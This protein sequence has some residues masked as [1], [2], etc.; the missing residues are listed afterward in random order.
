M[1]LACY[2]VFPA[3][4]DRGGWG[5]RHTMR[6][7]IILVMWREELM[8]EGVKLGEE[9]VVGLLVLVSTG[10]GFDGGPCAVLAGGSFGGKERVG[11]WSYS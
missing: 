7:W 10:A 3:P 6:G 1:G 8:Y 2:G 11:V 5:Y 9:L 4:W